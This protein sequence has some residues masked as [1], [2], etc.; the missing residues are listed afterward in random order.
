MAS[1]F[2]SGAAQGNVDIAKKTPGGMGGPKSGQHGMDS[3]GIGKGKVAKVEKQHDATSQFAQG[4]DT[5]MFGHQNADTQK[6]TKQGGG[7]AHDNGPEQSQGTGPK[8]ASGGSQ[9][10]FSYEPSLPATSGITSA[11]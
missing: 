11:R 2:K 3:N 1:G 4:G 6:G 9:K 7:T 8:F 5:P 10:M